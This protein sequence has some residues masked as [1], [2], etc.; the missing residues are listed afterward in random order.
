MLPLQ[1]SS[2]ET[3]RQWIIGCHWGQQTTDLSWELRT[4][5]LSGCSSSWDWVLTTYPEP[6]FESWKCWSFVISTSLHSRWPVPSQV[7]IRSLATRTVTE[8]TNFSAALRY[9]LL[10]LLGKRLELK[11]FVDNLGRK[12]LKVNKISLYEKR[13]NKANSRY[14]QLKS[15]MKNLSSKLLSQMIESVAQ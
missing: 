9:C 4:R 3:P 11:P 13:K 12:C 10:V 15:K 14:P 5:T 2:S 1:W 8:A 6:G 7:N